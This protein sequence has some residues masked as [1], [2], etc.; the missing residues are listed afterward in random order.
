MNNKGIKKNYLYNLSY[1]IFIILA[2]F[3]TAPYLARVLEP[4]GIGTYSFIS[5]VNSYFVLFATFGISLYGQ[6]QI[7]YCQD[8]KY[9][10]SVTFWNI[11][12]LEAL[13]GSICLFAY[14]LFSLNLPDKV[15]YLA[16]SFNIV[17]IILDVTWFFQGIE[18]FGKIIARNFF[19]QFANI[20][21]IFVMVKSPDDLVIYIGGTSLFSLLGNVALWPY[22]NKYVCAIR[23]RELKPFQDFRTVISMFVPTIAIQVYTVFDKTMIG[24]LTECAFENGYYEQAV[25]I[26]RIGLTIVASLGTVMVPRIGRLY[27]QGD[28][29]T[30]CYY[31]GKSFSFV[32]MMS[33]PMYICLYF[34]IDDFVPWFLG[35]GYEPVVSLVRILGLLLII[36]GVN[37]ITGIQYL[38]PTNRQSLFT[39]TVIAGACVN[40]CL[41]LALIPMYGASG[42]AIAS[43]LAEIVVTVSELYMI[44]NELTIRIFLYSSRN[45]LMAGVFL[46]LIIVVFPHISCYPLLNSI[47]TSVIGCIFY[48]SVLFLLKDDFF[49][50]N[51]YKLETILQKRFL[52]IKIR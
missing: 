21:F 49:V 46:L 39:A 5:S 14:F 52:N 51:F 11:K 32:W 6:R 3:I 25:R 33:I 29:K 1:Q 50:E 20:V 15:L 13:T 17:S 28:Y 31:I 2:P 40:F 35:D 23:I 41:N 12:C 10:R 19:I 34:I 4:D 38:I 36:I 37:N 16:M 22:I 26:S 44:R 18:E 8:E 47:I 27:S 45:Y 43:V 30:I 24:L 7:S 42:A 9:N 48:A